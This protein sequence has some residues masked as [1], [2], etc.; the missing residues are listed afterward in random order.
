[1]AIVYNRLK[2]ERELLKAHETDAASLSVDLYAEYWRLNSG[3]T[4]LYH[5]PIAV[6]IALNPFGVPLSDIP[7]LQ[8]LLEEIRARRVPVDFLQIFHSLR[9]PFYDGKCACGL[10]CSTVLFTSRH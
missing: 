7:H 10:S 5:T 6:S 3:P 9:I 2:A 8:T 4:C 1:M